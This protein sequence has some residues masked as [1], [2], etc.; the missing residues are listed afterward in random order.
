MDVLELHFNI[1]LGLVMR[2]I[3]HL[4]SFWLLETYFTV[5]KD[6]RIR[7]RL[8]NSDSILPFFMLFDAYLI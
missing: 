3:K 2:H 7:H 4:L 6:K 1:L 8:N 5:Q